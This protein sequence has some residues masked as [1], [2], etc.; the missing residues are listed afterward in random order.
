MCND[1]KMPSKWLQ[2]KKKIV[3]C[4]FPEFNIKCRTY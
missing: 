2:K 3:N 4:E 1:Y